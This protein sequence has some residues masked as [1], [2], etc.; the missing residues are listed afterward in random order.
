MKSYRR[1]WV[2]P[3]FQWPVDRGEEQYRAYC[4]QVVIARKIKDYGIRFDRGALLRH[5][6][7]ANKRAAVF[8]QL[9]LETTGL[10][11]EDMGPSGSGQTAKVK[12][13]FK[14]AGAPDVVFDKKTKEPQFTSDAFLCWAEDFKGKPFARPAAALLGLRAA[15]TNARISRS[16]Y[17]VL[18]RPGSDGRIHLGYNVIGTKG[19]RWSSSNQFVWRRQ[20]G[21]LAEYSLN[22][23]NMPKKKTSY[24]FGEG[25]GRLEVKTS[26]R[27]IV[28]ADK[29][30][31]LLRFDYEGAEAALIAYNSGD[32][33]LLRLVQGG[34]DIHTATARAVW[35]EARI[36]ADVKKIKDDMEVRPEWVQ[37]IAPILEKLGLGATPQGATKLWLMC[38]EACKGQLYG[39][40]YQAPSSTGKDKYPTLFNAFK[41]I[42]PYVTEEYFG[43]LMQRFF[44][45][46]AG[47][48][49]WQHRIIEEVREGPLR[50]P[51]N[52][53][54]L[55]LA[56][57]SRGFNQG[58]N[59][60]QQS[61]IGVLIGRALPAVSAH[62]SWRPRDSAILAQVH[63][64]LLLQAQEKD[65]VTI[66]RFVSEQMSAPANFG[67]VTASVSAEGD[68]GPNWSDLVPIKKWSKS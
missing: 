68:V 15:V 12:A 58:L 62:V 32:P 59:F 28:I 5:I 19:T 1:E 41:K 13:W 46:Y 2:I 8:M 42:F 18:N 50:L 53:K 14:E 60:Y 24:D 44:G 57:V 25:Y 7:K 29:G 21:T 31:V 43:V 20:D 34:L 4:E 36:P 6:Y 39:G 23:Q 48:R 67:N 47:L 37:P 11:R 52:G 45:F 65:A 17:A 26:L 56:P 66:E 27:D 16:Y 54:T 10:K 64:E 35:L 30:C 61:G 33:E 9:F 38:R 22:A 40:A 63:D 49:E 51:L 3:E 55:Y